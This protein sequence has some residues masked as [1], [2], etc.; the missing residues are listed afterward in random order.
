MCGTPRLASFPFIY[1]IVIS[2][3]SFPFLLT[4]SLLKVQLS[5]FG[6]KKKHGKGQKRGKSGALKLRPPVEPVF[7]L[8]ASLHHLPR[9]SPTASTP[10]EQ[11]L[12]FFFTRRDAIRFFFSS[13]IL[14][15]CSVAV[16]I[17]FKAAPRRV[18][19]SFFLHCK[20]CQQV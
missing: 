2:C 16:L 13:P 15:C 8:L 6:K 12:F 17:I 19:P 14:L 9:K 7:L 18:C 20:P 11:V 3:S 5:L 10:S 4:F 1:S